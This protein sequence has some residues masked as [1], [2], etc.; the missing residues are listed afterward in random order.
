MADDPAKNAWT[1]LRRYFLAGFAVWLP[2]AAVVLVGRI[3]YSL[4]RSWFFPSLDWEPRMLVLVGVLAV[5]VGT[6]WVVT[7]LR[8]VSLLLRRSVDAPLSRI[9]GVR[10]VYTGVKR[11]VEALI[12][13]R[14]AFGKVVLIEYP[15]SGA[16]SLAFQMA[17]SL[18]EV[19]EQV[20]AR[21]RAA[22][23]IAGD[24]GPGEDLMAVFVPTTPNPTSGFVLT[25]PKSEVTELEMTREQALQM[26]ISLGVVVP[27]RGA[28]TAGDPR[29]DHPSLFAA[30]A[31]DPKNGGSNAPPDPPRD[32]DEDGAADRRR[33]PATAPD[34]PQG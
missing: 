4:I 28:A 26:I 24:A 11:L 33:R 7:R 2:I 20:H 3:L 30:G 5:L 6:G 15:R 27:N 9:P 12:H 18:G 34:A 13:G 19:Q 32:P 8:V 16:Y 17:G 10:W 1:N 22:G 25:L 31:D 21:R 23:K 29:G 14:E